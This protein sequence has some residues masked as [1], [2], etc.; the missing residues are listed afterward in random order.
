MPNFE[1]KLVERYPELKVCQKDIQAVFKA[2]ADSYRQGGKLLICGNGGSA[3]DA[4]H[5]VG[6]LMKGFRKRR[7]LPAEEQ[8]KLLSLPGGKLLAE[9][10]QMALPCL[11]LTESTAL[12][13]AFANDV[14]AS[15][16]FAQ[17]VWGYGRA[18]DIW[19][20]ISTSGNAANVCNAALAAR[21]KGIKTIGLTGRSGG[22]LQDL[23][24]LLI[25]VPADETYQV[26]EY[27]L[28]VYHTLCAMLEEEFFTL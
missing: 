27:H 18:G 7:P 22:R 26:Q 19:L 5:I 17:Q 16:V 14:D 20:G 2:I 25:S 6:E 28:P 21:A 9:K 13:T 15:L 23:C 3:A 11:A 12:S 4:S 1:D 24:D 10:L 8:A